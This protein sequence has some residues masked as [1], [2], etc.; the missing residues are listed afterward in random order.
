MLGQRSSRHRE[1]GGM[2]EQPISLA[3][4][5]LVVTGQA[6]DVSIKVA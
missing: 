6:R 4:N 3:T 2:I 1:R 5:G